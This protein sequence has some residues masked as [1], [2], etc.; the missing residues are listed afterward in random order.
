MRL[1]ELE[2]T[3]AQAKNLTGEK[4]FRVWAPRLYNE[5]VRGE[6]AEEIEEETEERE[7]KLKG[8]EAKLEN[9]QPGREP[10]DEYATQR[11]GYYA[12]LK[13]KYKERG[14]TSDTQGRV[15][16]WTDGSAKT[17]AGQMRAGAG[18]FYGPGNAR[19]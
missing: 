9:K 19:N 2:E 18:I 15:T 14:E 17:I 8:K 3:M 6:L 4:A 13:S 11:K 10:Q 12:Y 16:V 5:V 1:G 7:S